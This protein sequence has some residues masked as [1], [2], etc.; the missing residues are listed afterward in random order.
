MSFLKWSASKLESLLISFAGW[1]STTTWQGRDKRKIW[2]PEGWD[3]AIIRGRWLVIIEGRLLF[4]EIRY[5]GHKT[6]I[7]RTRWR[8]HDSDDNEK[9]KKSYR[10]NK[11]NN[12]STRA[13]RFFVHFFTVTARLRR[14]NAQ[15]TFYG[16][17]KQATAKF[18]FFFW[19]WIWFLGR[20]SAQKEFACIW[21]SKR[22]GVIASEIEWK[23]IHFSSNVFVAV[24]V[25]VS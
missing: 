1:D 25:V 12:G 9:V 15:F 20:N 4:E 6:E 3:R 5:L 17:C 13:S 19:R 16:G 11:Q 21:Q 18:S 14:E 22:V 8:C 23:Q 7:I 10:L 24:A 2:W